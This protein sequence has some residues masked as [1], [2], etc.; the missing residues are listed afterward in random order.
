MP[1]TVAPAPARQT[2]QE[3]WLDEPNVMPTIDTSRTV[4]QVLIEQAA[5]GEAEI[6][7]L[8]V[9]H[10]DLL[11][12]A[13]WQD[14]SVELLDGLLVRKIR[15]GR[16]KGEEHMGQGELH[17]TAIALLNHVLTPLVLQ[18]E[19]H[20]RSQGPARHASGSEPE[21]DGMVLRGGLRDYLERNPEASDCS[22]IIEVADSSLR[23]DRTIKLREFALAGVRQYVI[24]NLVDRVLEVHEQ[25]AGE[26]YDVR[27]VIEIDGRIDILMPDGQRVAVAAADLLP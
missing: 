21:P 4:R 19:G 23:L 18:H 9:E 14:S 13:G 6:V 10:Y 1:S 11:V 3:S 22:C 15:E 12:E 8:S 24:V 5:R 17:W 7:P 26:I 27:R 16:G 2:P 20:L 25:P